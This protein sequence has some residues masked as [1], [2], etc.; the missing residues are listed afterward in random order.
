MQFKKDH[1]CNLQPKLFCRKDTNCNQAILF[2]KCSFLVLDF[3]RL[4]VCLGQYQPNVC[5]TQSNFYMEL[6]FHHRANTTRQQPSAA[7][8]KTFIH[9]TTICNWTSDQPITDCLL[10]LNSLLIRL[11]M[12]R[13]LLA[14]LRNSI[15]FT[16]KQHH[17]NLLSVYLFQALLLTNKR[18]N[19]TLS[20]Y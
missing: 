3:E 15:I 11:L 19:N 8:G 7:S 9:N 1:W 18:T 16:D 20:W 6:M 12:T 4:I 13:L 17:P 10:K 5:D 2:K 14:H